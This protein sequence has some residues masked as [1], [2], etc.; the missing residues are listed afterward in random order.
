[1]TP[2]KTKEMGKLN[3][4]KAASDPIK[5]AASR[6]NL[7]ARIALQETQQYEDS[8]SRIELAFL[9]KYDTYYYSCC[10]HLCYL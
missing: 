7:N 5:R 8:N 10:K 3:H 4:I 1:M 6:A 9:R 2:K